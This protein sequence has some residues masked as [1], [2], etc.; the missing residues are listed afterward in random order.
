MFNALVEELILPEAVDEKKE[1]DEDDDE[2]VSLEPGCCLMCERKTTLTAHHLIP[3]TV[4]NRYIK[5][6]YTR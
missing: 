4:H 3:K 5:K 1:D 2:Y 6:G